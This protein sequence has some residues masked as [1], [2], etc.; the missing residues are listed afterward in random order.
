MS[1]QIPLFV[2]LHDARR[3]FR[4]ALTKEDDGTNCP[5]CD[6]FAKIYRRK[7]NPGMARIIIVMRQRLNEW[8][9]VKDLERFSRN[10]SQLGWWGLVES[11]SKD[12]EEDKK[13]SGLWRLTHQGRL[14]ADGITRVPKYAVIYSCE[15]LGFEGDT[16]SIEE[17]LGDKFSYSKL[18]GVDRPS[19]EIEII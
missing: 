9:H 1:D 7:I 10:V 11:R 17:T 13:C 19:D 8:F 6:R 14:F 5:C 3:E 16:V 15:V 4:D 18:M 12:E 2:T